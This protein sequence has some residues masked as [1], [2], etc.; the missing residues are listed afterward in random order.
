MKK[1]LLTGIAVLFLAT[2]TAHAQG[3]LYIG[4]DGRA[5]TDAIAGPDGSIWPVIPT[6]CQHGWG[7][8][9]VILAPPYAPLPPLLPPPPPPQARRG[10][11]RQGF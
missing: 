5:H 4:R 2:G 1:T 6:Y 9:P 8:C 11:A 3:G 7:P 10:A